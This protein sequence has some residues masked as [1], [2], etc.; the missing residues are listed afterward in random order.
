MREG[1]RL[2][3]RM[4]KIKASHAI[5]SGA[6]PRSSEMAYRTLVE[7]SQDL[8]WSVDALGRWTFLN[9][10]VRR[11][12]GHE[13][14]EM[15]GRP[16]TDFQTTAQAKKDLKAFARIK[17]GTP[18]FN[19]ETVH[20]RKDGSAVWLSFNAVVTS[21]SASRRRRLCERVRRNSWRSSL[22]APSPLC[23]PTSRRAGWPTRRHLHSLLSAPRRSGCWDIPLHA[24]QKSRLF[25]R[26]TFIPTTGSVP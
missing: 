18:H 2:C 22:R 12:C 5:P 6:E 8:I 19:Y 24:G 1:P 23:S 17:A 3:T 11:I 10:A 15:L 4:K 16:F 20:L 9:S 21:P 13:P 26:T 14:A 25:C 7:T